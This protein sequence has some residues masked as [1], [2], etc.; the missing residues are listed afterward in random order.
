M[1]LDFQLLR[2]LEYFL[3]QGGASG[4]FAPATLSTRLFRTRLQLI[5]AIDQL[6]LQE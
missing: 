6:T 4:A 1:L 5:D 3:G 2:I